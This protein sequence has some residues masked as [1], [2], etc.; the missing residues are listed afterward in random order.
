VPGFGPA[1]GLSDTNAIRLT[2]QT[3]TVGVN[4]KFNWAGS[5]VVA[6]Y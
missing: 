6:R 5:P 2:I 3:A 4:Y 1:G